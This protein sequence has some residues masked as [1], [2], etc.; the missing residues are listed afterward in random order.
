HLIRLILTLEQILEASE[1]YEDCRLTAAQVAQAGH[2]ADR[3]RRFGAKRQTVGV[4]VLARDYAQ[5]SSGLGV[6]VDLVSAEI[7]KRQVALVGGRRRLEDQRLLGWHTQQVDLRGECLTFARDGRLLQ[8]DRHDCRDARVIA[9]QVVYTLNLCRREIPGNTGQ[10][11]AAGDRL[12][13]VE[14]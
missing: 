8:D 7:V 13:Q 6:E 9:Y 14:A 2:F 11:R 3:P 12:G 10:Q 1:R 4:H 5:C